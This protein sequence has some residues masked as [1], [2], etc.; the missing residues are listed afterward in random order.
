MLRNMKIGARLAAGFGVIAVAVVAASG[1]AL[2]EMRR[3]SAVTTRLYE[4]PFTVRRALGK[5]ET[6]VVKMHRGSVECESNA[7]PTEGPTG[8]TFTLILPRQGEATQK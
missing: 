7:D 6:S 1:F 5:A 4:H 3:L 2:V 8:T